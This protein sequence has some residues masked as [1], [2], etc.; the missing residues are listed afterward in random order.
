MMTDTH[1]AQNSW[2]TDVDISL[3]E[4]EKYWLI[5]PGALTSGLRQVGEF[6]IKV[7]NEYIA[8]VKEDEAYHLN[9]KVN[10]IV[11]VREIVMSTNA[12]M[13]VYARSLTRLSASKDVWKGIRV[14][15]TR[16]LAD[17][18]YNDPAISRSRFETTKLTNDLSLT[19]SLSQYPELP[20]G[21]FLA[22]RST[23]FQDNEGLMVNEV[24]LPGFWQ[25][26]AKHTP[27]QQISF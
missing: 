22:R 19:Q 11:W 20:Q 6:S 2:L 21:E 8:Y 24:F 17:I 1:L 16:P 15:N 10:D 7:L 5:R 26:L 18:L 9:L 14:L 13:A 3:S 27:A 12:H 25:E 23:F 4:V